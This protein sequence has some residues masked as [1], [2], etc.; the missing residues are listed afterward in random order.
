MPP[1]LAQTLTLL[2]FA[3][4]SFAQG[5]ATI[6]AATSA[7]SA[8]GVS[9]ALNQAFAGFGIEPSNLYSF[10]G[11]S[12]TNQLS[13][14]LLQNLADYAGMPPHLRIGG[15]TADQMI[16]DPSFTGY[17]M[18]LKQNPTGQGAE[19]SDK[20][21]FGPTYWTALNRFP[22]GTPITFGLTL[23]YQGSDYI[24]NIVMEAKACLN[25]LKNVNL[26]SFE[27]GNEPDLYL[28]NQ[29]RSAP[30]DGSVYT[31]QYLERASAVYQQVLKPAGLPAQFFE[32][33]NTASTIGTTFAVDDLQKAGIMN[34][35]NGSSTLLAAWNQH[36][37]YYFIDVST[38]TLTL[39]YLQ[40]LKN[41][42]DQ[43][44]YWAQQVQAA[45]K[46]GLPYYLREMASA[47]PTG[48]KGI[49]DTFGAALWTLNFFCYAA[50]VGVG[51]VQMHMTDNSYAAAWQPGQF[52]E[53]GPHVRPSYYAF[54]AMAQLLGAGNGTTQIAAVTPTNI[55]SNYANYVR[56]YAAYT[57]SELSAVVL[58]NSMTSNAAVTSKGSVTFSLSF[59]NA[60]GG[61]LYI[62]TLTADGGDSTTGTT[63]NGISFGSSDG[64]ATTANS[65][66]QTVPIGD[67]GSASVT[68]RDS[69]AVIANVGFLL[70]SRAVKSGTASGSGSS[71]KSGSSSTVSSSATSAAITSVLTTAVAVATSTAPVASTTSRSDAGMGRRRPKRWSVLLI[72]AMFT[73]FAVFALRTFG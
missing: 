29:F 44:S 37:Y 71:K 21:I 51:S 1:M 59:P 3:A 34:G 7:S 38:Y 62:S 69:Q 53:Q 13:V 70:G 15:N 6:S 35:V 48:V 65:A 73:I 33:P 40:Q 19:H 18:M 17:E 12:N 31:Q 49:S 41:T 63:W 46:T 50:S 16:Y 42:E 68:V 43:F 11:G 47:G 2:S 57:N 39:D 67:D 26:Y 66:V 8:P 24:Q 22:A 9:K 4:S 64:T 52:D 54:A 14:N 55:P 5:T 30:W 10:T 72:V 20:F 45:I 32:A 58:I 28:A 23:A 56:T 61:T 36:D 27:I 25:G 60:K